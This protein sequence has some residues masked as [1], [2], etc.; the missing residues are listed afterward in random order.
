MEVTLAYFDGCPHWRAADENVRTALNQS[1]ILA[2]LRYRRV[3]T[4]EDA[5]RLRFT[6]SPTVLIDG[7]DPF[8]EQAAPFGLSCRLYP[9]PSGLSGVP[10]IEQVRAALDEAHA[11][12]DP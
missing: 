4:V 8:S 10:T 5:E 7:V 11:R 9:T 3:A 1:G 6:G 12:S 2:D